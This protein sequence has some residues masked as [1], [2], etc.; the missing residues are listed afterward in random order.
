MGEREGAGCGVRGF[1]G[2]YTVCEVI[3]IVF[4]LTGETGQT[5]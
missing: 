2:V 5:S 4:I 1:T 3:F